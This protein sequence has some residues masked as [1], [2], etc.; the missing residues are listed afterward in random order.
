MVFLAIQQYLAI[1]NMSGQRKQGKLLHCMLGAKFRSLI[2]SLFSVNEAEA[3]Y[4]VLFPLQFQNFHQKSG[5]FLEVLVL[6][7][8]VSLLEYLFQLIKEQISD[9]TLR[10]SWGQPWQIL[11]SLVVRVQLKFQV[12]GHLIDVG[13][14]CM[15]LDIF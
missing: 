9:Q 14:L 13:F 10:L 15:K 11:Y 3:A 7:W 2:I 6:F 12:I 8:L 4:V 1:R 5:V